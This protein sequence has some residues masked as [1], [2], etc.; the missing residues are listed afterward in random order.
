MY[1]EQLIYEIDIVIELRQGVFQ[2]GN[3][4]IINWQMKA[5]FSHTGICH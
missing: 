1:I 4:K 2:N 3:N 5:F